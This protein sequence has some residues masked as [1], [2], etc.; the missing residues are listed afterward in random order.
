[1]PGTPSINTSTN[2]AT[3]ILPNIPAYSIVSYQVTLALSTNLP[4]AGLQ[5]GDTVTNTVVIAT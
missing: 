3:W 4:G 1:M 2:Q 5:L